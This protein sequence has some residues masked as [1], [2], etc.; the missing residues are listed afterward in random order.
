MSRPFDAGLPHDVS[1]ASRTAPPTAPSYVLVVHHDADLYGADKSLLRTLRMLKTSRLTPIVAV[2]HHGP[3]VDLMRAEG[4]EVHIGPV[5]KLTR[6]VMK[7]VALPRVALDMLASVRFIHK[8][9]AGRDVS[10]AYT[11][12]V[13]ALGGALWARLRGTPRL[14][15]VREIVV[16]PK[17]AR[18]AFPLMLRLL[19]GW[20]VCN[21]HATRQWIVDEQPSLAGHS[22]VIWNGLEETGPVDPAAVAA[23]RGKLGIAADEVVVTMVGRIN[24]WKGQE[25]LVAAAARLERDGVRDTR[26]LIVGDVA[27]GQHHFREDML[28]SIHDLGL[29]GRVLWHPFTADVD[30]VWAA[31]DIAVAPSVWPEPFGR[32]AIEAMAHGLPVLASDHGGLAEIVQHDRTGLLH[33]PADSDRLATDIAALVA[34]PALRE[35][36]GAAGLARQ[37]NEFTQ[38]EHDRKLL[39]LMSRLADRATVPS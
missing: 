25:V 33:P 22:S 21:S 31:S 38:V 20:C 36:L 12:S 19:G 37:R 24:R 29:D 8:I 13:A 15:H 35:A 1:S 32:V 4:L 23:F 30:L 16:A 7:P 3:L 26:F 14:W 11:N 10:L 5:G 28:R 6:Q 27:D 17:V 9:V 18:R 39:D 34:S 2:P